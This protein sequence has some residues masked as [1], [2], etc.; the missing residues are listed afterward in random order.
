MIERFER[1]SFEIA[2]ISRYWYKIAAE[3]LKKY[4]LK[5]PHATYLTTMQRYP[6]GLTGPQLCD[7]CDKDKSDVS[8]TM[9]IME[10]KGLVRK[11]GGHQ[12]RYGGKYKLTE[13]G[14]SAATHVCE[15]ASLAVEMASRELTDAQRETFYEALEVISSNLRTI[16]KEGLPE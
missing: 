10:K 8:R 12:N 3:E 14:R 2:A 9:A 13:D 5:G 7:L 11:E 1:F 6:E 16:S 15:R 4:E